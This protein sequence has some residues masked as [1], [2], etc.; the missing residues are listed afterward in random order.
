MTAIVSAACSH[1]ISMAADGRLTNTFGDRSEAST[2]A[3]MHVVDGV[4]VVMQWGNW[5]GPLFVHHLFRRS[6]CNI[7]DL[8]YLTLDYLTEHYRPQDGETADIGFHVGGFTPTGV[9]RLYHIYFGV[10]RPW[11]G[12]S[13]QDFDLRDH[14]PQND[15][16]S[17]LYNGRND[18]LHEILQ[19]PAGVDRF[20]QSTPT[21]ADLAKSAQGWVQQAA[22]ESSEVGPPFRARVILPDNRIEIPTDGTRLYGGA[23]EYLHSSAEYQ[24][25]GRNIVP[26]A[27]A[28]GTACVIRRTR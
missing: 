24:P 8:A 23:M 12:N 21:V 17:F 10:A 26:S 2:A 6:V 11:D 28:R 22:V 14:S 3:K 27:V 15:S 4:G 25:S 19:R 5:V 9:A 18:I 13:P 16:I 1:A 20:K 7:D